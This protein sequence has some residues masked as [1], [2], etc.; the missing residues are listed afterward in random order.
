MC[1]AWRD[2][3]CGIIGVLGCDVWSYNANSRIQNYYLTDAQSKFRDKRDRWF[4]TENQLGFFKTDFRSEQVASRFT[5][6]AGAL[7]EY[8][9]LSRANES[10]DLIVFTHENY[11]ITLKSD[12]EKLFKWARSR[13]YNFGFPMDWI[14]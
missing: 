6:I 10:Y 13:G 11:L 8:E 2:A 12:M 3:P 7:S 5:N 9:S 14:R 4:D 1:Q